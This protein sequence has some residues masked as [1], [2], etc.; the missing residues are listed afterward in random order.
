[1]SDE[2]IPM[3]LYTICR[4]T[5]REQWTAA[6][7]DE[8]GPSAMCCYG[9]NMGHAYCSFFKYSFPNG[10]LGSAC[11]KCLLSKS[12]FGSPIQALSGL[13]GVDNQ[14]SSGELKEEQKKIALEKFNILVDKWLEHIKVCK[15]WSC[16]CQ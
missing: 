16:R 15:K 14:R 10:M 9:Y 3:T 2:P 8:W 4:E 1:M 5:P 7:L 13:P 6:S 11:K 12:N